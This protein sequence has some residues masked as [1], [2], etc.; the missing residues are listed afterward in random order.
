MKKNILLLFLSSLLT[1][2]FAQAQDPIWYNAIWRTTTRDSAAYGVTKIKTD[3]GFAVTIRYRSGTVEMTGLFADDS[4]KVKL[5]VFHWYNEKGILTHVCQFSQGKSNGPEEFYDDRGKA[6]S[7]GEN[8]DGEHT[9]TWTGYYPSGKS[10]GTAN[11]NA[12]KLIS[13]ALLN[14]DGSSNK[15]EKV[16]EKDAEFPGGPTQLLRYLNKSLRYPDYAV[17]HRIQG[18]VLV[19]FRVTTE[20]QVTDAKV[21]YT[22]DKHLDAEAVRVM[23]EMPEWKP[24]IG[25]GVPRDTYKRQPVVFK[26]E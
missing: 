18:L 6:I 2:P 12:G 13:L 11:F 3:S 24:G 10:A 9:G 1:C 21:I 16:F 14:E 15:T 25:G 8:L 19:Q 23:R 7:K 5:G 22:E 26:L 20:G 17:K 4:M